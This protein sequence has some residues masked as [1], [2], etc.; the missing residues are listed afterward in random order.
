MS[1]SQPA[2]FAALG[3]PTR[4]TIVDLLAER[5][6]LSAT[7]ISRVFSSTASAVSQHLKVLRN[8]GLVRVEKRAQSRI[9]YLDT[10]AI[11]ETEKWLSIRVRQWD[12]RLDAMETYIAQLN[13][14]VDSAN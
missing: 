13:E 5:G 11:I 3:D 2:I 1:I 14:G 6:A 12:A 8:A 4:L 9:Y 7:Q 10:A